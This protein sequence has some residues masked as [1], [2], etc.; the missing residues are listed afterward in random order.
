[1]VPNDLDSSPT[2]LPSKGIG[3][4]ASPVPVSKLVTAHH[5]QTCKK[6]DYRLRD[7]LPT[8]INAGADSSNIYNMDVISL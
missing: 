4:S 6:E 7:A 5:F 3:K 2:R 8:M 1:M